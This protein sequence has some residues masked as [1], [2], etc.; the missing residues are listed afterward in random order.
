MWSGSLIFIM[1]SQARGL[2]M[3]CC[4]AMVLMAQLNLK[5]NSS[6]KLWTSTFVIAVSRY[7]RDT[8][9]VD[10]SKSIP[11][12]Q[13]QNNSTSSSSNNSNSSSSSSS[14]SNSNNRIV[15][16]NVVAEEG[17]QSSP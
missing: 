14:S 6:S 10:F 12:K 15:V 5:F 8:A 9:R 1:F 17:Y 2:R 7:C 11:E 4:T 3:P 13:Q 16:A